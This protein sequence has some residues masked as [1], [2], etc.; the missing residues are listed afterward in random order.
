MTSVQPD[1]NS[2]IT[3]ELKHITQEMYKKNAELTAQNKILALLRKIDQ[4]V[5]GT[6]T[7]KEQIAD[8]V[9]HAMVEDT[10]FKLAFIYLLDKD[11]QVFK[12]LASAFVKLDA[13]ISDDVLHVLYS[14]SIPL[15]NNQNPLIQTIGQKKV[16]ETES[17]SSIFGAN[18]S[19]PI[20]A[21]IQ[22]LYGIGRLSVH[23]FF[24]PN[25]IAGVLVIGYGDQKD[26]SYWKGLLVRLPDVINISLTN[27]ILFEQIRLKNEQLREL[28]KL[29]DEFVSVASHELRTPMSAT[30]S[31]LWMALHKA[32]QPL[33]ET[34]K[35][36]I[37]IAYSSTE[38][39]LKLVEDMLTI[40][41]IEGKRLSLSLESVNLLGIIEG[42]YDELRIKAQEKK[43]ELS[44]SSKQPDCLIE[45][46][47]ERLREVF[48]NL[49]G[50]ALKFTP[51]GGKI[52]ITV[53]E[54]NN[55][56]NIDVFNS[57][58]YITEED[59]PKLFQKFR[60]LENTPGQEVEEHG[61]GLGLFIC[62]Q[63]VE[64]HGG[65]ITVES[66]QTEGTTFMIQL[67]V[68]QSKTSIS[69]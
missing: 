66:S 65:S 16:I 19:E 29:K 13:K 22:R 45:G 57:G 21:N 17:L 58:S 35:K 36:Y 53:T 40:S 43:I 26:M 37:E 11:N 63:I 59:I 48:Q 27:A 2:Q 56:V 25:D 38:R 61:S 49:I 33:D 69:I 1:D 52:V 68:K 20:V 30:K 28:D 46:D 41:R 5:L 12:P 67:P 7:N 31:Y 24:L 54:K 8:Q 34:S 32:V 64:M 23:P 4:I 10:D 15:S 39:L 42:I 50:N 14:G 3:Q 55:S 44:V 62:K 47:K 51:Q 6:F 18:L 60:K 9:T